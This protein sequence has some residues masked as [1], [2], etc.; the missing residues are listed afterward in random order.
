MK[1]WRQQQGYKSIISNDTTNQSYKIRAQRGTIVEAPC[2]AST[3]AKAFA[4]L[5]TCRKSL[6]KKQLNDLSL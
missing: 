3:S 1:G 5:P 4:V 6:A 2:L